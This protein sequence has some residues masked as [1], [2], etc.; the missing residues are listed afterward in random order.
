MLLID[1]HVTKERQK[2]TKTSFI[3]LWV[4]GISLMHNMKTIFLGLHVMGNRIVGLLP[5]VTE[6]INYFS[7]LLEVTDYP[8]FIKGISP[9]LCS[10]VSTLLFSSYT[11]V[12]NL[13]SFQIL[14]IAATPALSAVLCLCLH[15]REST[16]LVF[17]LQRWHNKIRRSGWMNPSIQGHRLGNLDPCQGR[18][19]IQCSL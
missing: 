1:L 19:H 4:S 17:L 11:I 15:R 14:M 2:I 18:V 7:W 5:T 16:S 13:Q 12:P 10:F 6:K 3:Y 8:L 9:K